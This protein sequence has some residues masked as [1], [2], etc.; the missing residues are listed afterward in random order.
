MERIGVSADDLAWGERG[1]G[2][3]TRPLNLA[4]VV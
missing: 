3:G 4:E 1:E 2:S